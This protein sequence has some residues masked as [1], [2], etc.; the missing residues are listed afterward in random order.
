MNLGLQG[1]PAGWREENRVQRE[2]VRR[3]SRNADVAAVWWVEGASEQGYAHD[4]N[5]TTLPRRKAGL[6]HIRITRP[7]LR[8]FALTDCPETAL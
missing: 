3:R 7:V 2:G 6:H 4:G 1:L 5:A 8:I